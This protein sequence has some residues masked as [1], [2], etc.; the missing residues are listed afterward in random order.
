MLFAGL[1]A[2]ALMATVLCIVLLARVVGSRARIERDFQEVRL[3]LARLELSGKTVP[4][5]LANLQKFND[6]Y[7]KRLDEINSLKQDRTVVEREVGGIAS[8]AIPRQEQKAA[9]CRQTIDDIQRRSGCRTMKELSDMIGA[10]R[11][12]ELAISEE[13]AALAGLF[14]RGTGDPKKDIELWRGRVSELNSYRDKAPGVEFTEQIH[15]Q[16]QEEKRKAEER[17]DEIASRLSVF[18]KRFEEVE[19][20][21]NSVLG[22]ENEYIYCD[23]SSDLASIAEK[24]SAF[25]SEHEENRNA[26]LAAVGILEQIGQ[27]EKGRVTLLFDR[28]SGVSDYFSRITGGLYDSVEFDPADGVILVHSHDGTTLTADKLSSGAYDQLY[29]AVRLALG[30]RIAPD[31]AGF[32]I[33]D[34]PFIRSD[35]DR[36]AQ[37]MSLL[38]DIVREGWQIIYFSS[39]G[40]VK[41]ALAKEIKK[42]VV[43]LHE[44]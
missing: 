21:A 35:P 13:T 29:L 25:A 17:R 28:E 14:E 18:G 23:T 8:E 27:E 34:D 36:L 7:E 24:L 16:K 22:S 43:T 6:L 32:F 26:A 30:R 20:Q 44:L 1:A 38:T 2:A 33:M 9:T 15:R 42:G 11:R 4:E 12:A 37:Q 5:T 10:K 40:E 19:R 3:N 41:E 39:K 31:G